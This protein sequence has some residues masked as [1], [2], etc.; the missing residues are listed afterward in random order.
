[1]IVNLV[2]ATTEN[3]VIGKDGDMPWSMPNDLKHFQKVTT[4]GESNVVIMG[5]KTY[6]SIGKA[7]PGRTNLIITR[8]RNKEETNYID[9]LVFNTI[10]D[11]LEHV[12]GLEGFLKLEINVHIIGGSSIY[13][14][15]MKMDNIDFIHHT[16]IK[17]ELEGDTFFHIP[18]DWVVKS[19]KPYLADEKHAHDYSFRVL[20]KN[21]G[22]SPSEEKSSLSE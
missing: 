16:L 20:T 9:G 22:Q 21:L 19:E 12:Q 4:L 3:G 13:N 2:V 6:D 14:E 18:N 7:L 1:M 15:F 5:R 8:N 11:A 17:T 10:E